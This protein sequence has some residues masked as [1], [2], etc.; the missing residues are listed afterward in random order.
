MAAIE[1]GFHAIHA[2]HLE[3]LTCLDAE[4]SARVRKMLLDLV[5]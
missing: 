1:P 3:D 4:S 2:N 5:R